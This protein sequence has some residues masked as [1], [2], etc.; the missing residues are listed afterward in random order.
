MPEDETP[1]QHYVP[2]TVEVAK[3][4]PTTRT[5]LTFDTREGYEVNIYLPRFI[6]EQLLS[7]LH[8]AGDN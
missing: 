6:E 5:V 8:R 3:G 2:K 7:K 4:T 1:R